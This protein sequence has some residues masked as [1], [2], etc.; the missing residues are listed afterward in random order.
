M[1]TQ[2]AA[3]PMITANELRQ[4]A[5]YHRKLAESTGD[6]RLR[7]ARLRT[8]QDLD[9]RADR[10]DGAAGVPPPGRREY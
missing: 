2:S 5:A 3:T 7:E 10:I 6:L 1:L 4:L 9:A 8:A